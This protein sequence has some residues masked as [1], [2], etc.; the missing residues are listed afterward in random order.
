MYTS[1]VVRYA[2]YGLVYHYEEYYHTHPAGMKSTLVLLASSTDRLFIFAH[3]SPSPL[4][5]SHTFHEPKMGNL[6]VAAAI[7]VVVVFEPIENAAAQSFASTVAFSHCRGD[8]ALTRRRAL[9]TGFG[10]LSAPATSLLFP[11]DSLAAPPMASGEADSV[12]ARLERSARKKP[13]RVLRNKLNLDF[14]VLLMRS[15]Y[16]AL[17]E[18]DC[19]PMDQFQR[20]FFLIRQAEYLPYSNSL[21]PGAVRQGELTDPYY[22]DFISFA[23]YATINRDIDKPPKVFEEQQPVEVPDGELQKFKGVVVRRQIDSKNLAVRHGEI[24]GDMILDRL[25]QIFAA[26][27][28][29]IPTMPP[30]SRPEASTVLAALKQLL[31]LFVINGFAFSGSAAISKESPSSGA[32]TEFTIILNNPATLWSGLALQLRRCKVTND[33]YLKT[34]RAMLFRAGYKIENSKVIYEGG[35]EITTFTVR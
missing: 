13:P 34:A 32:G 27:D 26:T 24:V 20:D 35:K 31:V 3:R 9:G 7:F 25:N 23:Q 17:D 15:S 16:A 22:F 33:F 6:A 4:T 19:V 8:E 12:G 28:S 21:G 14:G 18:L 30:G 2:Y 5:F 29:A 10:V 1:V 11:T